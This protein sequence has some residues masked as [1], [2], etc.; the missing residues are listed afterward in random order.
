MKCPTP[1]ATILTL[2]ALALLAPRADAGND[3][4][5]TLDDASLRAAAAAT[6]PEYLELLSLP[7]DSAVA[8]DIQRNAA[9]L[10]AAFARRGFR[11]RLLP[12]GGKPLVLAEHS[13]NR[14][15]RRTVLFYLHFDGQPVVPE[16]WAQKNPF[17]PVVKKRGADGAWR[18][19]G[20][21]ELLRPGFDPDLRVFARSSADDKGPIAMLLAAFDLLRS[22]KLEPRFD[23]K[24]LLDSE[25]EVGSPG[26]AAVVATNGALLSADALVIHDG[27]VHPG[28][29]PTI[30]F[31]NRGDVPVTLTVFG[32]RTP[33]HSGHY[34]NWVPNPAMRLS[35]LLASMKG[36][37]GRVAVAGWYDRTKLTDADRTLLAAV[38]DDEAAMR[39]RLGIAEAEKVGATYQEALQF[40]SL[41]VRGLSSAATGSKVANVLPHQAVAEL[42]L[43]TTPEADAEVLVALLRTHVE[44]QGWHL[45]DGEPTD[46]ERGLFPKLARLTA[47]RAG[48]A[49]RQPYDS[50]VG[51]WATA[52]LETAFAGAGGDV[53]PVRIRMMGG[54]VPTHEIVTPLGL[55]FVIVPLVNADNNQHSFDENLRMGNFVSGMRATL[56]LLLTDYGD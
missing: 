10:E 20:T 4:L 43:R 50:T 41:N 22:R 39:R 5:R 27:P 18:E 14:G 56:G 2:A 46:E 13:G 28:G 9:W 34:G 45:V 49:A 1:A 54:T 3:A 32:P 47:G 24:V 55:P 15:G 36:D 6:F 11:T 44:K 16:Q 25:E 23:V 33:L 31:G 19:V 7:N 8:A 17:R 42:D 52:A 51:R 48:K 37:D 40:P 30:V 53:R 38:P 12:N 21:E 26:M 29:R 35:A